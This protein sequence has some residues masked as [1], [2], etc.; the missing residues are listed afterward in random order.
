LVAATGTRISSLVAYHAPDTDETRY[1]PPDWASVTNL[2][3][4]PEYRR[5]VLGSKLLHD[6]L[7]IAK[8]EKAQV[9]AALLNSRMVGAE[10]IYDKSGFS[11]R[12]YSK[13]IV[14]QKY[15]RYSLIL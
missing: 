6:C 4:L 15:E 12:G 3:V 8:S 1:F 11:E 7:N 13:I 9:F 5:T 14:G 10:K 2:A